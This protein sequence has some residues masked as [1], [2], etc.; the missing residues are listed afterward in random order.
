MKM[1][2]KLLNRK[3]FSDVDL[4]QALTL[5]E[6]PF[7]TESAEP[8]E[9][10]DDLVDHV[11]VLHLQYHHD[12]RDSIAIFMDKKIATVQLFDQGYS[13]SYTMFK[14]KQELLVEFPNREDVPHCG[15]Y[16]TVI[17]MCVTYELWFRM[18]I[19]MREH[20]PVQYL[21]MK[22][23]LRDGYYY[24][25][26]CVDITWVDHQEDRLTRNSIQVNLGAFIVNSMISPQ[27]LQE[28]LVSAVDQI[29]DTDSR[30]D[31]ECTICGHPYSGYSPFSLER[32][33]LAMTYT[34]CSQCIL[35]HKSIGFVNSTSLPPF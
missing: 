12:S 33:Y 21:L 19:L 2:V 8:V 3:N 13:S 26:A 25:T 17:K 31:I 29:V 27:D 7:T 24:I 35:P 20:E 9:G 11:D 23:F 5:L 10:V 4:R 28:C 14:P 32:L 34:Y 18:P 22:G 30:F 1:V 15:L 6:T 16:D